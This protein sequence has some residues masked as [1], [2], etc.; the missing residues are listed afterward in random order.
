VKALLELVIATNGVLFFFGAVQHVGV[1]L[2]R[3]HE[4]RIIPAAIVETICGVALAWA[5]TALVRRGW[6]ARRAALV[7]NLIALFGVV[8][9]L[10]AL[11][12][13]AGP[14]TVSNDL[15]HKIMLILIA[16][17]LLLIWS[18]KRMGERQA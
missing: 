7:A 16:T 6:S 10:V 11:A 14:R 15:Y 12:I 8:I 13:G 2:G 1:A 9:G 4:P 3:F 18:T 17:A 5:A